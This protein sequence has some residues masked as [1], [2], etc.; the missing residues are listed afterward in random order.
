MNRSSALIADR[1]IHL[2]FSQGIGLCKAHKAQWTDRLTKQCDPDPFSGYDKTLWFLF[3]C[4]WNY[5]EL[6]NSLLTLHVTGLKVVSKTK[7]LWTRFEWSNH[8]AIPATISTT[9]LCWQYHSP[10]GKFY[11]IEKSC[12][13]VLIP[14]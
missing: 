14:C 12:H 11:L 1:Q 13:F 8:S 4:A 9:M 3:P 10:R 7:T 5:R 2:L 6:A